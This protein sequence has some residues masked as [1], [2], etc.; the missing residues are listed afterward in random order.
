ME[1]KI[2]C[3]VTIHGV[4]FEQPPMNG[5]PGYADS[6]HEHLSKYL[7]ETLLG[8]DPKR[9]RVRR[10]QSGP[11]YI[12]GFWPPGSQSAEPEL[13]RLGQWDESRSRIIDIDKTPLAEGD[14]RIV[15]IALVYTHLEGV[16]PQLESLYEASTMAVLS[17]GQ[18]AHIM[19]LTRALFA[20]VQ[21]MFGNQ[22][23]DTSATRSSLSVRTDPN[24]RHGKSANSAPTNP[25]G[26]ITVIRQLEND[27]AVY[28][29]HNDARERVR[30]FVWEVLLRLA[31]RDD[32]EGI[33]LNGHSNGTV[34]AFD[35]L[36]QFPPDAIAKV[37]ALITSGS[38]LRKYAS[39]FH[40][41]NEV[42]SIQ[43]IPQWMNFWDP[44][45]PVGDPLGLP[46]SW[47]P[48]MDATVAS[49]QPG[50]YEA[51]DVISGKKSEVL[52][53]DSQINNVVNSVG[54]GL[55]AHNYWD[56]EKEFVQPLAGLLKE[57]VASKFGEAAVSR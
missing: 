37:L 5:I 1:R 36:R 39:L 9:E 23:Q 48:G 56:N 42:G 16:G 28:V 31:R 14:A 51:I 29:C 25:S 49:D 2:I 3:L 21:A 6:L 27:V 20:D 54:G 19:S 17:L 33:V 50:L 46:A 26:L 55:Q 18:Y 53:K 52:I 15:H 13:A 40:W 24:F 43:K 8:D 47:H 35:V 30:D 57:L 10:G 7:D 32:V 12:Q 11:I 34:V 45:D 4:G 41:G 22:A 44:K 38:P